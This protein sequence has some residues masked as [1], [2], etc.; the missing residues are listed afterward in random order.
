MTAWRAILRRLAGDRGS[1]TVIGAAITFPVVILLISACFQAGFWFAARDAAI[2]AAQQGADAARA[3]GATLQQG[4]T[5]A[6]QFAASAARGT[7]RDPACTGGASPAT[8]TI[9]VCG[10]AISL[11]PGLPVRACEQVQ[12]ARERFTTRTSP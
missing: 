5:S 10:N 12:G 4:E 9:T 3:E 2:A 8:I 1:V 7:L 6:C 11:M